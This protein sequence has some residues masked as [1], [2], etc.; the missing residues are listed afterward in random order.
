R[1][2]S[3]CVPTPVPA[4][5]RPQWTDSARRAVSVRWAQTLPRVVVDLQRLLRGAL[6]LRYVAQIQ[7]DPR[8][9]AAAPAHGVHEDVRRLE[10][11]P[12]VGVLRLPA[13]QPRHRLVLARRAGHLD[14]RHGA[15]P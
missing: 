11:R 1:W 7:P 4:T 15:T 14:E 6:L 12:H 8:P 5:D 13:L 2:W 10:V 3:G 9:G